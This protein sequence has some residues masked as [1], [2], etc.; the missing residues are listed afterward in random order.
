[1]YDILV[2]TERQ[3]V[4][5]AIDTQ[6]AVENTTVDHTPQLS[7]QGTSIAHLFYYVLSTVQL[8]MKTLSHPYQP[9]LDLCSE[10]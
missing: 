7:T 10:N 2:I 6:P 4:N 8:N 3:G 9:C 5:A 1:M